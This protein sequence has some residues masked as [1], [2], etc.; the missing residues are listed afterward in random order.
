MLMYYVFT[1]DSVF[2][3]VR[4]KAENQLDKPVCYTHTL[5]SLSMLMKLYLC[6]EICLS[7]RFMSIVLYITQDDSPDAN[8]ISKCVLWMRGL[9]PVSE[10]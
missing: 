7:S 2:K 9:V 4:L 1:L 5:F 3:S 10:F 8:V 6:L